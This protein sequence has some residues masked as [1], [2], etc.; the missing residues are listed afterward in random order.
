MERYEYVLQR[1]YYEKGPEQGPV[2][3]PGYVDADISLQKN[4]P[5]NETMRLQFR[6][7][8][9]NAFNHPN[10]AAPNVSCCTGTFGV[11]NVTQD[12][13]QLQFDLKFYF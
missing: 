6:A 2:I 12:A 4:F 5:I 1:R 11:S 10:F 9:L 3:G 7:D 8:F 13:R